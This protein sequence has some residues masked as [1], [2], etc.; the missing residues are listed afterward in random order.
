MKNCDAAISIALRKH[1][2]GYSFQRGESI[3]PE[4]MANKLEEPFEARARRGPNSRE[5]LITIYYWLCASQLYLAFERAAEMYITIDEAITYTDHIRPKLSG[6]FD[7]TAA[8][9]H[10]LNSLLAKIPSTLAPY[11]E[12]A[13]RLPSLAIGTW[14]FFVYL[15][16]RIKPPFWRIVFA[17][18]C[19]LPYYISEYWSM[20]RGYFMSTCFAAAALIELL[21]AAGQTDE[22]ESNQPEA[23]TWAQIYGSLTLLS[24]FVMLPF[25]LCVCAASLWIKVRSQA[26]QPGSLLRD[27]GLAL[28]LASSLFS[29]I[30]IRTFQ[31]SGEAL[32]RGNTMSLTTPVDAVA[33][34]ILVGYP[35]M[36]KIYGCL[37]IA[38]VIWSCLQ[39]QRTFLLPIATVLG[40]IALLWLGGTLTGGF[41]IERSWIPYWFPL[42]L[43]ISL[44]A[45]QPKGLQPRWQTLI[46][47]VSFTLVTINTLHWYT[48][49]FTYYYRSNYYQVKALFY[50][51]SI[52][53]DYCLEE[54]YKGD[55]VL[56]FYWDDPKSAA[57]EPRTCQPGERSP[58]GFTKFEVPGQSFRFPAKIGGK[59][60]SNIIQAEAG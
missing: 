11:S 34:A 12:L 21:R 42:C 40:S 14:F 7:F 54:V 47:L 2:C 25:S 38:S 22:L 39:R 35:W 48:P 36:T 41:P 60:S 44:P 30:G 55:K 46:S 18:L 33:G 26:A 16:K 13:M 52:G 20:S 43:L 57:R 45:S 37:L 3:R 53:K 1:S 31:A 50:Y 51:T 24:S 59:Y 56:I 4:A 29:Y 32:A 49:D 19:L 9:N 15:P 27:P 17:C 6:L 28:T 10:F 23:L 58:L 8:N 5:I